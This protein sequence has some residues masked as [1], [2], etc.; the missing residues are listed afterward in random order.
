MKLLGW[1]CRG[2]C[3]AST[4]RALK[5]Q[6]KG[7]RPDL[8]FLSETK[9][10]VSRMDFVKS[11]I[12]FD[13]M[14][15]VEAKGKEGGLYVLWKEGISVKEVEYNKNL[16]AVTVSYFVCEWLMVGFYGPP[17]FSKKK[18]AWENLMALLE[19][20]QGPWMCMSDFNYV[21]NEDEVSGGRKG[22]SLATNYLKELMFEF[23]AIDL[24]FSGCKF[25]SAKGRWGNASIKRRLNRGIANM[26]WRLAYPGASIVHFGTIKSDHAPILLDTNPRSNFAHRPFRFEV[27]W[28]RDDRSHEV[29]KSA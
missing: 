19:S 28:L 6:I 23:G 22:C 20:Y 16:I 11:S 3:N 1:N 14:L 26:S 5:A 12:G 29:I 15:V 10:L 18:K 25:I 27:T 9:A 2:I 13:N 8:V 4:V 21:I 17:Y 24:G 7:V